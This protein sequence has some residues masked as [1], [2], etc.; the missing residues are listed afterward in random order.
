MNQANEQKRFWTL[1]R[2]I[3]ITFVILVLLLWGVWAIFAWTRFTTEVEAESYIGTFG[4]SF[5]A[6][7]ALFS[8]LALL[9]VALTLWQSQRQLEVQQKELEDNTAALN[10]QYEELRLQNEHLSREAVRNQFFQMLKSW[11][12]IINDTQATIGPVTDEEFHAGIV[13]HK[14]GREAFE[15]MAR[16]LT[17]VQFVS[18]DDNENSLATNAVSNSRAQYTIV[19]NKYRDHLGH[20]FRLLYHTVKFIHEQ[21]DIEEDAKYGFA[22]ILRA[23]LSQPESI[24]L[25]FNGVSKYGVKFYPLIEKYD[26][27]QNLDGEL[28][29]DPEHFLMYPKRFLQEQKRWRK[30]DGIRN[31]RNAEHLLTVLP[32]HVFPMPDDCLDDEIRSCTQPMKN[33]PEKIGDD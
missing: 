21:E 30:N 1:S 17:E 26:L 29:Q 20:Y 11:Q 28:I 8:G 18:S 22:R 19:Y 6:I 25:F 14:S 10:A 23:H 2:L 15:G 5:G 13:E 16:T 31:K 24:L 32:F 27:L 9:F 4:D 12:S 3:S 33:F 7:N